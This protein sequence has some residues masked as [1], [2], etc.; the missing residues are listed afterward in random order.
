MLDRGHLHGDFP[1]KMPGAL[2][3]AGP[4]QRL[5][6]MNLIADFDLSGLN[7][8]GLA[9]RARF[10]A[11]IES[12]EAIEELA[13][14]ASGTGLPLRIL[15]GG[16]NVVLREEVAAVVGFMATKGKSI[17]QLADGSATV[18]AQAGEDWSEFVAWTISQGLPGLENLA[19]IPG[20]VGAAPVQ[21]IGAYGIE[22]ADRMESLLVWDTQERRQVRLG[23]EDC[24]FSYRQSMFKRSGNRFIVLE[25]TF[26]LPRDWTPNLSY[27]GLDSLP[28]DADARTIME[29]V[30][31]VRRAKL[32]NWRTLGNVG[33]FF[34]NPIVQP[35]LAQGI[36]GVPRYPQRDGSVKLSAAW[37][38]EACGFKGYR[39]GQAGVYDK[40]ALILVN[41]GGATYGEITQLAAKIVETVRNRF[42]VTLIQEPIEP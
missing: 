33:S 7:T 34:H 35:E 38:I 10:G 6:D 30:L 11:R 31:E 25:V 37:L 29:R 23:R 2:R 27:P 42:G 16:S 41:H 21:N 1:T 13:A 4:G 22:L 19:G 20:T 15:G 9:A 36:A 8:L 24:D 32:P 12:A 14:L 28:S 3:R 17:N 18:T 26:A 5:H 39:H 40:H